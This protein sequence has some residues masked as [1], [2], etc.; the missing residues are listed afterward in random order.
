[1]AL[2]GTV[3]FAASAEAT[4]HIAEIDEV[5]VSYDGD[6]AVQFVEIVMRAGGQQF[7]EGTK[8]AAFGADG[9]FAGV[10]L[11]IGGDVAGGNGRSWIMGTAAFEQASG[12]APD[13][14]FAPGL[15]TGGGMVCWG[16]PL[17][18]SDPSDYVDCVAYGDY[19]GPGN[20]HTASPNPVSPEGRSLRRIG[21]SNDSATDFVCSD[22][23]SPEN[24]A[25]ATVSMPATTPCPGVTST[26]TSTTLGTGDACGD[27]TMD[28][29][30][31]ASD[32]LLALAASVGTS[33]CALCRCDV[34]DS[35]SIAASDALRILSAAVGA[36]V[37]LDCPAC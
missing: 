33:Q 18:E 13:F 19:S 37:S 28:E 30:V 17:Q 23:A 14:V 35:G 3:G 12:L 34:D 8:L 21:D 4:F 6:A 11:T 25:G 9:S 10:V 15:P 32:A 7:V 5:M 20:V 31:T 1:V 26:T 27:G 2:A 29:S 24:N 16:L 36:P 22:P